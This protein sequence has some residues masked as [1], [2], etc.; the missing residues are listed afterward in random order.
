MAFMAMVGEG[1]QDSDTWGTGLVNSGESYTIRRMIPMKFQ[2]H[3]RIIP[4]GYCLTTPLILKPSNSNA[5]SKMP[6]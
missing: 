3:C 4:A 6:P 2:S 1:E 5:S